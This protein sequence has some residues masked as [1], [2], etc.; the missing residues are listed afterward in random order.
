MKTLTSI[1]VLMWAGTILMQSCAQPRALA[2]SSEPLFDPVCNM[3]IADLSE[4]YKFKYNDKIYYFDANT[5]KEVFKM[6]PEK[7][8]H[9]TCN[10]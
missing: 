3:K 5:C 8:I 10:K 4:A 6:N 1:A 2:N 7:F 9:N